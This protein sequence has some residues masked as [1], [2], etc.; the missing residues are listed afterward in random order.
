MV[1]LVLEP[2]VHLAA[3]ALAVSQSMLREKD[4][5]ILQLAERVFLQSEL[6][7]RKAEVKMPVAILPPIGT[8]LEAHFKQNGDV[9]TRITY[10][11]PVVDPT[12]EPLPTTETAVLEVQLAD[13]SWAE[14]KRISR[15]R[16]G[17]YVH[18]LK[19]PTRVR[20]EKEKK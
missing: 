1:T 13:G 6:L 12:V 3:D 5:L 7:S 17:E 2:L 16:G 20:I 18:Y 15:A 10:P 8:Q 9:R 14:W 19:P 4:K 11:E